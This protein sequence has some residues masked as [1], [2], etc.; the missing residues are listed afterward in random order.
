EG[1][2]VKYYRNATLLR[3]VTQSVLQQNQYLRADA[4]ILTL[5]G[6]VPAVTASFD[7][8][9]FAQPSFTYPTL[10]NNNGAISLT[11]EGGTAPYTYLWSSG[12]T[13]SSVSGKARGT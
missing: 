7:Q 2:S 11:P 4:S 1:T 6:I 5:N 9:V 3:T 8:Q 12:E 10:A 13:T